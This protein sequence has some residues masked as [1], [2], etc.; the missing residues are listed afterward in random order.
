M[1]R[2]ST[3]GASTPRRSVHAPRRSMLRRFDAWC[4][5]LDARRLARRRLD[6]RCTHLDARCFGALTLGASTSTLRRVDARCTHLD[7]RCSTHLRCRAR[8]KC[9]ASIVARLARRSCLPMILTMS[10]WHVSGQSTP[11]PRWRIGLF[12]TLVLAFRRTPCDKGL[13]NQWVGT[14]P[15]WDLP[16]P[17]QPR[18]HL[19]QRRRGVCSSPRARP[20]RLQ[21]VRGLPPDV[22]GR[23][24]PPLLGYAL[25]GSLDRP[26]DR[27]EIED[28]L[29][30]HVA[31]VPQAPEHV[32][33]PVANQ[34]VAPL[35]PP[36]A[37]PLP[38]QP[39]DWDIDAISRDASDILGEDS[40]EAEVASQHSDQVAESEVMDTDD[41]VWSV[42]DRATCH[43]G[44]DWPGTELPRRSLFQSPSVQP[45]QSRMLPA[46]PDFVKEVQSTWGAPASAPATSRK[47]SAFT[48]QGA[49]EAGLA[50]FPPVDAA[51][52]ALRL[53]RYLGLLKTQLAQISSAGPQRY[54]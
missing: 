38:V 44:I 15:P 9:R 16:T 4:K 26:L 43:L 25:I 11:H 5:Y 39:Q 33:G 23:T 48:M 2:P 54:T 14:L 28:A 37:V 50:S 6:A 40:I 7:A 12:A 34:P 31:T 47:A 32:T 30:P 35:Q 36:L 42:V 45:H 27:L 10:A 49:S 1:L 51:F 19:R 22:L 13:R 52:A 21:L 41:T 46:F 24:V 18:R 17:F 20:P 29:I 3:L 53:R 8:W